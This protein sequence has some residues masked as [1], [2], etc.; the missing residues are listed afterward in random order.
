MKY[1]MTSL[2]CICP[3]TSTSPWDPTTH[4]KVTQLKTL[5]TAECQASPQYRQ[6]GAVILETLIHKHTPEAATNPSQGSSLNEHLPS[7]LQPVWVKSVTWPSAAS[8][9]CS[10]LG[11]LQTI[12]LLVDQWGLTM[13]RGCLPRLTLCQTSPAP[14]GCSPPPVLQLA[15]NH[16]QPLTRCCS[17][18]L[19]LQTQKLGKHHTL[20]TNGVIYWR[21]LWERKV[22]L[23]FEPHHLGKKSDPLEKPRSPACVWFPREGPAH[24][25]PLSRQR[26]ALVMEE[27]SSPTFRSTY[28]GSKMLSITQTQL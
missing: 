16:R 9:P 11:R 2:V 25:V 7:C 5:A 22:C 20:V 14:R 1:T 19:C 8:S 15:L 21:Q 18:Q 24:T 12:A 23:S 3:Q 28:T 6:H 26:C 27:H 4:P 17:L 10:K 13:Q